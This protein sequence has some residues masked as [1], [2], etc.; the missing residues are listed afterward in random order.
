MGIVHAGERDA[1]WGLSDARQAFR[2]ATVFL[3]YLLDY[4]LPLVVDFT[5]CTLAIH[6]M[7][8]M[9]SCHNRCR[10]GGKFSVFMYR[11]FKDLI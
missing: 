10:H 1:E 3:L 9:S 8:I 5:S 6:H 4:Q 11:S 7:Y 2:D